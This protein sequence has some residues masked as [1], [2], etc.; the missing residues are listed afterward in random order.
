MMTS[1]LRGNL[2]RT[3][4]TSLAAAH[5]LLLIL[6]LTLFA[7]SASAQ[8]LS[9]STA[10]NFGSVNLGSTGTDNPGF[11]GPTG[12]SGI[13]IQSVTAV[14]F[15]ASSQDFSVTSNTCANTT[16]T[17]PN[18]CQVHLA[19]KPTQIGLRLGALLITNTAGTVVNTIYLSGVGV[20]PQFAFSPSLAVAVSS[21]PLLSPNAFT[22]GAAVQ[23][24]TGDIFFTDVSDNRILEESSTGVFSVVASGSP[25]NLSTTSGLAI[26]G[27]GNLYVSSGTSVYEI[28]FGTSTPTTL[29]LPD[30]IT[31]SQPA[32]LAIDNAGDLYIADAKANTIYQDV[33]E[34]GVARALSL[35]G[36]GAHL[37]GP[38]GL[39]IDDN[40]N[41][42]VADTGNSRIVEFPITSLATTVPVTSL[43]NPTGVAV[44]AAG[45]IYVADT[46]NSRIFE[47]TITPDQFALAAFT[48]SATNTLTPFAFEAPAGVLVEG[49]GDLI[50]SD[51]NLGL[52]TIQR[53]NGAVNFPTPTIVGDP[54]ST[55]DP[56][57]LTLQETGNINSS[58]STSPDPDFNG[59]N[60]AAFLLASSGSTCPT[61][62]GGTLLIGQVCNFDLD[63]QPTV[64]GPN[65]ANLAL[66]TTAAGVASIAT[67]TASL[68][69]VGLSNV[70]YFTL[71]AT[72]STINKGSSV[73]L[74]LTAYQ[75]DG[76]I[77]TDFTGSVTFNSSAG[78]NGVFLG[79]V[80]FPFTAADN[81]VLTIPAATGLELN[82]YGTYTAGAT[83][84]SASLSSGVATT[85]TSNDIYVVEPSTLSLTSS[86]NPSQLN[87][88]TTFTLTIT[89]TGSNP[90]GGTVT[91]YNG[92]TPIGSATVSDTSATV[93]IAAI[94][95]SFPTAGSY[96]I[97][98]VYVS[99]T[100]TQGGSA[101][102]TQIVGFTTSVRL[103]SSVNPV[104]VNGSTTLTAAVSAASGVATGTIT[105]QSNGATIGTAQLTGGVA[106][107]VTSFPQPGLY[108]LVAI[109]S[110]DDQSSTSNTVVETVLGSV[111]ITL[112]SS[113]NPVFLDNPT[114]LTALVTPVVPGVAPTG[115]VSFFDGTT[116]IGSAPVVNGSASI[117]ASFVYAGTH[118]L[119]AVYS[120]GAAYAG[121]T[122]LAY[123]QTV[124]DFSLSVA[125][126]ASSSGSTIAGGTF[127]YPLVVTPIITSTL[128]GP[129]TLTFS[130][131]PS[132]VTGTLTPKSIAAGAGTTSV[133]FAVTAANLLQTSRLHR[134]DPH[135]PSP[136]SHSPLS[137]IPATMAMVALPL[138]WF[139]RR[140]R[141]AS[142]FASLCLLVAITTGLSGCISSPSSGYY[143]E[144]P[145]TYNLTVT[146]TSG[147]L[148]RS[149]YLKLTVQ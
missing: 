73:E 90:P 38:T 49:N 31:L 75:S 111:N 17:Y 104:S 105:F 144:T 24:A 113:I 106:T 130:G 12:S 145:Q 44:D 140:N 13:A 102:L 83:L 42:Y 1:S 86:V 137:Y 89:T 126:G 58:L 32:G 84:S 57:T 77:A 82:A 81:G 72:P 9:P 30:G 115:T 138:A 16:V 141:F 92:S 146:A 80:T 11:T 107:L 125:S 120:G 108:N 124:A 56:E 109:Y 5:A 69:G 43:K 10:I 21:A 52:I 45:T 114:V 4:R 46:G 98:A 87:Q 7:A 139:R 103:S 143:G 8:G 110:G 93:G 131:L 23:D 74:I 112:T 53:S 35:T 129:I 99:S 15:G 62:N 91:F 66:T 136:R 33:L 68:Y 142:L 132:T 123:S 101:T 34:A 27:A 117:S 61:T 60:S 29:N 128:P 6:L 76:S 121:A 135:H 122:S 55:D 67:G 59:T 18:T 95:A 63:F 40:N 14:T 41:L 36:S 71:V 88:P 28:P 149:T 79:G 2:L 148:T 20:A 39:A 64:V 119:T 127:T 3:H 47:S 22:S 78:S 70:A 48:T 37:S 97:K 100:N 50:V 134:P 19:F 25:L 51:T 85:V 26:D 65:T 147:N 133:A 96:P 118:S 94:S 116:P 54:D